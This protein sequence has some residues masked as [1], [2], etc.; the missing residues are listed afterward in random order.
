[1]VARLV[2]LASTT[3][4]TEVSAGEAMIALPVRFQLDVIAETGDDLRVPGE[5]LRVLREASS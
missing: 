4:H 3:K 1:V 2:A 5:V